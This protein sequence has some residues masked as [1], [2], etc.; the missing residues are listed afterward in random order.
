MT[1]VNNNNVNNNKRDLSLDILRGIAIII[2][3]GA[4]VL[5]YVTSNEQHPLWFDIYSS[6]A[7]PLFIL[8][9]GYMVAV[10]SGS[11][12]K[13]LSYYLFRGGMLV[14]TAALIDSLIWQLLPFATFDVLYVIG[15]GLPVVYVLE[16]K[17][18]WIKAVFV[19]VILVVTAIL[20]HV[21]EYMEFPMEIEF[22]SDEADYSEY[23]FFNVIKAFLYD[24]WFPVFP[25]IALSVLGSIFAHFRK[26]SG[27]NFARLPA[28]AI[29]AALTLIGGIWLYLGYTT[30]FPFDA[31]TERAP[32]SELFYP[33]TVPFLTGAFGV[34][35]LAFALVDKTRNGAAWKP[36]T[37]FGQT[38]LFNYILHSAI[39]AYIVTPVF[40][41]EEEGQYPLSTGWIVYG[42][43]VI[44]SFLLSLVVVTM[45]KKVKKKNFLFH[46][47]FGS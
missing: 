30:E 21:W 35:L 29:G 12:H 10:N 32:Y 7:A 43:L 44:V 17:A 11:K 46:F 14:L 18:L 22:L 13:S 39:V 15:L 36:V 38:S 45:K 8:L 37:I 24:G 9:S 6:F 3:L 1:P 47:Y 23:S 16:K 19:A 2:M 31:L 28:V 20:Q 4:N 40:G 5:G 25:W 42:L 34:S 41:F 26:K 33:A 27:N